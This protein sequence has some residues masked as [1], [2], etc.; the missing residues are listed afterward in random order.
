MSDLVQCRQNG[1]SMTSPASNKNGSVVERDF[2][3][4]K[5]RKFRP[6][7]RIDGVPIAI[8]DEGAVARRAVAPSS[9]ELR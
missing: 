1:Y 2:Q 4:V 6:N 9:S 5:P 7:P 3:H 8:A